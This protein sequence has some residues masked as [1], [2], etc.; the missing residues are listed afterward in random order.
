MNWKPLFLL[1]TTSIV[2]VPFDLRYKALADVR[3][4]DEMTTGPTIDYGY[5]S[6]TKPI[7][8]V[9]S[10]ARSKNSKVLFAVAITTTNQMVDKNGLVVPTAL[11]VNCETG[12]GRVNFMEKLPAK[13]QQNYLLD[14]MELEITKFCQM[15]KKLWKH[16]DW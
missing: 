6:F 12:S 1:L 13:N 15:H 9:A 8:S 2:I 14:A 16:S 7:V 10:Y 5:L 11:L 4:A 3:L